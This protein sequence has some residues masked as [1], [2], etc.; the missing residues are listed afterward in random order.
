MQKKLFHGRIA[1][2]QNAFGDVDHVAA[3]LLGAVVGGD[4]VVQDDEEEQ[5]DAH[6]VGEHGQLDVGN[7]FDGKTLNIFK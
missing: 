2:N 6:Q 1:L 3:G 4:E 5:A 7:H